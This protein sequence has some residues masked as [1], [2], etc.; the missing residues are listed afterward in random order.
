ML[1]QKLDQIM[2]TEVSR[3]EFIRYI[4]IALLGMVGVV[5]FVKNLH[6]LMP[7]RNKV[8]RGYGR[9]SYGR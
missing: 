3:A 8:S 2:E 1:L 9:S 7:G 5:G 4:G 6:Q